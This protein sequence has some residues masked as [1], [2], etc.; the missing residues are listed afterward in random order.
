MAQI[1][2]A[3]G[4]GWN[5]FSA[6]PR[7]WAAVVLVLLAA[8]MVAGW[9]G[10]VG[11]KRVQPAKPTSMKFEGMVGDH[12]LYLNILRKMEAGQS[13]Y[14]AATETQR[15]HRY[16][17]H[18]FFTVRLPTQAE[19][20][21]VIGLRGSVALLTLTGLAAILLWRKRLMADDDLPRYARF[22]ALLMAANMS[23]IV[24]RQWVLMHEVVAGVLIALALALYRPARPW[25]A[26]AVTALALAMR[27]TVLPVAMLLGLFALIDRDWRAAAGWLGIGLGFLALM[28]WHA[29]TL[30]AFVRPDDMTTP[31]WSGMGG[32]PAYLSFVHV[33][34]AFRFLPAWTMVPVVPLALLGWAAWRSRLGT[35]MLIVQLGYAAMLMLFARPNNFYWAM[36]IEPTLFVGLIFAPAALLALY[37][38]I[39]AVPSPV[40]V[41]AA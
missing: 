32:W 9:S 22:G 36:L 6:I 10:G 37:R 41:P 39:R 24:S 38:S 8:L 27:E 1:A 17:L 25:P 30:T 4:T 11:G 3:A 26:M 23:Q 5:R 18:P 16:P 20:M 13:Y 7:L 21:A 15:A 28:A 14:P 31:G 35:T 19:I 33:S 2:P 34:S 40:S 29:A 12:A